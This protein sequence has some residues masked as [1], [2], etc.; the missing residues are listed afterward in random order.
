M[1]EAQPVLIHQF[2]EAFHA[3]DGL[4][5]TVRVWGQARADG[6]WIGWLT[7][8]GPDGLMTRVTP[9]ETTQSSSEQVAYWAGGLEP[10]YLEGA[11]SRAS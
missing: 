7:F 10:S 11:F 6:T 4:L 8:V 2:S 5:Y 3:D 9:R 1:T